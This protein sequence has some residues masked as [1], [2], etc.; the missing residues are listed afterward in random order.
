MKFVKY[1]K[2]VKQRDKL[3]DNLS[4]MIG[5]NMRSVRISGI[6]FENEAHSPRLG[7]SRLSVTNYRAHLSQLALI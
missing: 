2:L 6:R 1:S 3:F 7:T 5:T 4:K